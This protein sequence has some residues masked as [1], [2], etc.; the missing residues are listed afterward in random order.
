M[1]VVE[2]Y[3]KTIIAGLLFILSLCMF[4][5]GNAN[6]GDTK[7]ITLTVD[8]VDLNGE[9]VTS[10]VFKDKEYTLVN[11]WGTFCGP[12]IE[13]MPGLAD[14][15]AQMPD[16]MQIIGIVCDVYEDSDE[17]VDDALNILEESGA[18]NFRH[19]RINDELA[20][21]LKQFKFVPTTILV[22][23]EGEMVGKAIT[24]ADINAYKELIETY[25]Q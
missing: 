12:C 7:G 3:R 19:L 23:S 5:C 10:E 24:G 25:G 13:E 2:K 17:S 20:E 11:I 18:D 15:A 4:G 22:N 16:N 9:A 8:T 21:Q 6:S 1:N 14:I